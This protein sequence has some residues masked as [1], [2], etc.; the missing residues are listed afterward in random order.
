MTSRNSF[1]FLKCTCTCLPEKELRLI[2]LFALVHFITT[3]RVGSN[4]QI[5]NWQFLFV[6]TAVHVTILPY[7]AQGIEA[8]T[9]D[10]NFAGAPGG[11]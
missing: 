2:R 4:G 7:V 9:V 11:L 6:G 3:P 5:K 8:D 10:S 1:Y